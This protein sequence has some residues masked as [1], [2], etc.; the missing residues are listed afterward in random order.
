MNRPPGKIT[1]IGNLLG[2]LSLDKRWRERLGLHAVFLFWNEV[3]G[4][5][6]ACRAQPTIIRGTVLWVEVGDPVWLQQLHL[7]RGTLLGEINRRLPSETKLTDI[8]FQL[9]STLDR[10]PA[11]VEAAASAP[12]PP[13][14]TP[15]EARELDALL[16]TL[17]DDEARA[18]MRRF[19]L[20]A[21]GKR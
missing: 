16:A 3:V 8:R 13:F 10:E 7:Q 11:P 6:I 17:A 15:Q 20:K 21:H 1:A 12:A 14:L 2:T 4:E 19:W 5:E 9:N 18:T